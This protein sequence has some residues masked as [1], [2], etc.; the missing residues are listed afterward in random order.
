MLNFTPSTSL[1]TELC[2]TETLEAAWRKVR[3]NKGGPG[4]DGVTIQQFEAD[5]TKASSVNWRVNLL[6]NAIIRF[7]FKSSQSKR[8]TA[9]PGNSLC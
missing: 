6:R 7:P 5:L 4:S 1:T 9:A 3:I 8:K 2:Q